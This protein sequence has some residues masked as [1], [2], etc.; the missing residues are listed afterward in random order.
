MK[1]KNPYRFTFIFGMI[2]STDF[3]DYDRKY[4]FFKLIEST[5][6]LKRGNSHSLKRT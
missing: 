1:K 5:D 4:R 2:E 3:L 6:F